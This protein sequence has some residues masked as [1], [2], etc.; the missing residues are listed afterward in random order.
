MCMD[1][2]KLLSKNEEE[3]ETLTHTVRIHSQDIR[4]ESGIE[5]CTMLV[6]KSGK[7]HWMDGM[8]LPN[9]DKIRKL[10]ENE[11]YKY[12]GILKA[13]TIKQVE[14]KEKNK[15]RVSQQN[16][17]KTMYQKPYQRN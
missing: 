9:Q 11:T 8:E 3:L 17:E 10:R 16:R 1:D 7:R 12:L 15:E 14:M 6:T 13:D 5:K 4:M 2:I